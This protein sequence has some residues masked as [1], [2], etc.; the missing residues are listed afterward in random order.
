MKGAYLHIPFCEHICY[1][2]DFNKFFIQYQP[3][4][5]YLESLETEIKTT[6]NQYGAEDMETIFLG[7]GTPTA[8]DHDQFETLLKTINNHLLHPGIQE[9]TVEANPENMTEE[10]LK[11]MKKWGVNRLSVGVQTFNDSLLQS[12]G[13]AHTSAGATQGIELAKSMGL[14]NISVD[15]MFGLPGQTEQDLETS[16]DQALALDPAHISIYSLQ[17]EPRTIFYNRMRKGKLKLP[18]EEIEAEMYETIISRLQDKGFHQ[19]EISNF[20]KSGF[21]SRHNLIYWN[22]DEY[23]GFGAGAHGYLEGERTVNAGPMRSFLRLVQEQGTSMVSHHPVSQQEQIEEEMFLG[24]RK[25]QG[26]NKHNF[27]HKYDRTVHELYGREINDLKHRGLLY[28]TDHF[29]AL[30]H[31]GIFLGNEVFQAFLG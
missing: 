19:Y 29:L 9:F 7:G 11:L 8:L 22:N 5:E 15:L 24:L 17:V 30:T 10:K 6:V 23:F 31:N 16:I 3:V 13:R 2:C 4:D 21:E 27:Y 1:Y 14:T 28:E 26:V 12:I 20:S 18:A 25:I